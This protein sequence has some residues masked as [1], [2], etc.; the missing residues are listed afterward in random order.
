MTPMDHEHREASNRPLLR[1]DG[2]AEAEEVWLVDW[3][4][5]EYVRDAADTLDLEN[6]INMVVER[7]AQIVFSRHSHDKEFS[8]RLRVSVSQN[9]Y[10]L[11]EV[12][13]GRLQLPDLALD[14]VISFAKVQAHLR[15]PQMLSLIHI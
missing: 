15:I 8:E 11:R 3:A 9:A 6:V 1:D 14:Q 5:P 7:C 12:L 10:S 13:A 4:M 2:S